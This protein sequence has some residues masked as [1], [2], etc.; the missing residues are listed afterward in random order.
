MKRIKELLGALSFSTFLQVM[1]YKLTQKIS[2]HGNIHYSQTGE[3]IIINFFL[4]IQKGFFV[5]VGCN[6]PIAYSNTFKFYLD[7]WRGISIDANAELVALHSKVRKKDTVLSEA[8]SDGVHK[9]IFYK[10]KSP[11]V[12]TID[13]ETFEDWNAK[14]EFDKNDQ[15]ELMTTTLNA[16]LQKNLPK[17]Q[18][19][20]LLTIDVEGHD[21]QVLKGINLEK[22]R[23]KLIVVEIHDLKLSLLSNN[24]MYLYLVDHK[25][26]LKGYIAMNA[27]FWDTT[28][29]SK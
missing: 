16:I 20:D 2:Q 17:G 4:P 8:V 24:D 28:Q 29:L 27:Y 15:I 12:S 5:D 1:F 11:E 10:S 7:G 25:Y 19:I 6:L 26:E 21:F 9:V 3:D 22:Y 14:W 18:S 13:A 23:P